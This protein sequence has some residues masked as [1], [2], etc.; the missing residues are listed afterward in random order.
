MHNGC[1]LRDKREPADDMALYL[2]LYLGHVLGDFLLQPG[3][4]VLAK[5]DGL[6]GL[7]LHTAIHAAVSA[8]VLFA[9]IG[10]DWPAVA[11]V[12]ALHLVIER[13]TIATY[14]ST[15]TRG[16]FTLVLDQTMHVLSVVLVVWI[17]GAWHTDAGAVTF[18]A[19][20]TTP[21]LAALDGLLTASL[22]GSILVFESA[23]VILASADGGKGRVLGLDLSRIA[24]MAERGASFAVAAAGYPAAML[25]PFIPRLIHVMRLPAQKRT[26]E[27][28]AAVAGIVL[29]VT[30]YAGWLMLAFVNRS[31]GALFAAAQHGLALS[32]VFGG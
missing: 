25:I 22:L 1:G 30:V 29:C 27:A 6:A 12:V 14:L 19:A 32:F 26:A 18:G 5:R 23:N 2:N 16:L 15:P 21:Q 3:R 9:T 13:L 11:L 31:G 24:G 8:L 20:L 4:L 17:V 7:I 28:V 10:Q